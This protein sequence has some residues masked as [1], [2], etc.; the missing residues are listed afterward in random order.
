MQLERKCLLTRLR[1]KYKLYR[2]VGIEWI[3]SSLNMD[4]DGEYPEFSI[5]IRNKD[6]ECRK[7]EKKWSIIRAV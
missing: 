3:R 6:L 2:I 5:Q 1:R 4:D 7:K